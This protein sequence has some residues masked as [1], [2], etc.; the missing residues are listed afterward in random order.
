M[1][2]SGPAGRLAPLLASAALIVSGCATPESGSGAAKDL[3]GSQVAPTFDPVQAPSVKSCSQVS[4]RSPGGKPAGERLPVLE[5]PC[6]TAGPA[7]N[8]SQ[9]DG[10]PTVVNL[11]A[12]WCGPCRDEMPVLQD[13]AT[14]YGDQ[15]QFLGVVTKDDSER[16]GAFLEEL[17]VTYPQVVDVD[18]RLLGHLRTPG[19]PVTIVLDAR[20]RVVNRQVGPVTDAVLASLVRDAGS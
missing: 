3:V 1:S 14:R 12:T 18:G 9:L 15:V 11:W 4:T 16:A 10:R 20:G 17:R 2:R 7:V 8:L 13:A 6:L 19:L 5:L